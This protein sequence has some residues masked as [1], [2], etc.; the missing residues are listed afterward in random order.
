MGR[1]R[2]ACIYK[3]NLKNSVK[4]TESQSIGTQK[5][6]IMIFKLKEANDTAYG[7]I[8]SYVRKIF[9]ENLNTIFRIYFPLRNKRTR[10]QGRMA[11][12]IK[13]YFSKKI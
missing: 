2:A 13:Y 3:E 1:G 4:E 12:S 9:L 10:T 5:R 6:I 8:H 7:Y 11:I